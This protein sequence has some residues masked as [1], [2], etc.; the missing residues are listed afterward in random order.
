MRIE[1]LLSDAKPGGE[2]EAVSYTVFADG[3]LEIR[4]ADGTTVTR[5]DDWIDVRPVGSWTP[6]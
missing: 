3:K 6:P 1:V 4:L 2:Y 5:E